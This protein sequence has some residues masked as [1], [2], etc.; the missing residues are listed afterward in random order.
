VIVIEGEFR[1]GSKD[2]GLI[3]ERIDPLN[4][5]NQLR[6]TIERGL[7][8]QK[9][10]LGSSSEG[11]TTHEWQGC[12]LS[13]RARNNGGGGGFLEKLRDSPRCPTPSCRDV[14]V[15]SRCV[16]LMQLLVLITPCQDENSVNACR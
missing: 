14:M 2:R 7:L 9:D 12:S 8:R 16:V 15:T 5:I 10:G 6:N 3:L 13:D 1:G 4:L 11:A